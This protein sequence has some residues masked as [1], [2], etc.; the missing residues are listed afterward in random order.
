MELMVL[1][2][3]LMPSRI[4]GEACALQVCWIVVW[5]CSAAKVGIC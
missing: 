1:D 4:S 3:V 2:I 5:G